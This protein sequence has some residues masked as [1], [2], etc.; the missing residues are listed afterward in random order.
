MNKQILFFMIV[1]GFGCNNSSSDTAAGQEAE[2]KQPAAGF[3]VQSNVTPDYLLNIG[4]FYS[5]ENRYTEFL[6]ANGFPEK[7]Q[8]YD[9]DTAIYKYTELEYR[10]DEKN[11]LAAIE[12]INI[13]QPGK[14]PS[15]GDTMNYQLQYSGAEDTKPV[16]PGYKEFAISF[17]P[18]YHIKKFT[19]TAY[20]SIGNG[21]VN[22]YDAFGRPVSLICFYDHGLDSEIAYEKYTYSSD[23]A[24]WSSRK[25]QQVVLTL[26]NEDLS[27]EKLRD[28][29]L[30]FPADFDQQKKTFTDTRVVRPVYGK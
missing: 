29:L 12:T 19:C 24:V 21:K 5:R 17:Y 7:V 4:Y 15:P 1:T 20:N 6:N 25:V 30:I 14:S 8:V 22:E 18:S 28:E 13:L 16:F 23:S 10:Y 2:N 26:N 3:V 11:R 9:N 27:P